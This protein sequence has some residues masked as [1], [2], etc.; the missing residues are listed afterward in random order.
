MREEGIVRLQASDINSNSQT[1]ITNKL[2]YDALEMTVK[3]VASGETLDIGCGNKP[4]QNFFKDKSSAYVGC[5]VVQ[6]SDKKVDVICEAGALK[7]NDNHFN[8]AFTTQVLEH[9]DDPYK[10]LT[11]AHRV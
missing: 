2:L 6:S 9:V 1:Y 8:T 5:D 10:M 11:E 4:Y 7:F 3:A